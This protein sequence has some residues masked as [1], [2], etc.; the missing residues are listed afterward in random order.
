MYRRILCVAAF[1]LVGSLALGTSTVMA[2]GKPT[3]QGKSQVT[4]ACQA[5]G[6][7]ITAQNKTATV[8]ANVAFKTSRAC[9]HFLQ[10]NPALT[11]HSV[12]LG[13]NTTGLQP[14]GTTT[15]HGN[16]AAAQLC[17]ARNSTGTVYFK[18]ASSSSV[19]K[20]TFGSALKSHGECVSY[21]AR[22]KSLQ[23]VTSPTTATR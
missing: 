12:A 19:G 16:S 3:Q 20:V 22:N 2:Q 1:A 10:H 15:I 11:V 7:T 17:P 21:F 23:I 4:G 6:S 13:M 14:S 5:G 8:A 18:T 9:A